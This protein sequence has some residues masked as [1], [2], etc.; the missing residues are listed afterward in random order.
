MQALTPV[1]STQPVVQY[2]GITSGIL[3]VGQDRGHCNLFMGGEECSKAPPGFQHKIS[4]YYFFLILFL[5][6][7]FD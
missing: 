7:N 6:L 1:V 4:I 3:E 2:P 5:N